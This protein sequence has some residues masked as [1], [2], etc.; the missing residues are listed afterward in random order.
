MVMWVPVCGC[1]CVGVPVW[2]V[3]VACIASYVHFPCLFHT[4]SHTAVWVEVCLYET[5]GA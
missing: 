1:L 4:G 2:C 3:E 5:M